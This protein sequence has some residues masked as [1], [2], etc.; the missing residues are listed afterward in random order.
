MKDDVDC[1]VHHQSA[2]KLVWFH[3]DRHTVGEREREREEK[4]ERESV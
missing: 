2:L 3:T 1:H 4:R